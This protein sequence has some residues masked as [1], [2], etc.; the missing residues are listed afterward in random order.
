MII[1]IIII[2][3]T[4]FLLLIYFFFFL[5]L[6]GT[7]ADAL[8]AMI[9]STNIE[10]KL[11]SWNCTESNQPA[12]DYCTWTGITCDASKNITQLSIGDN[13][14]SGSQNKYNLIRYIRLRIQYII[15]I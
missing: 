10:T 13:A 4:Y 1:I 2:I 6:A 7:E 5:I 8:C 14:I 3:Y 12:T 9:A 11:P 15:Y